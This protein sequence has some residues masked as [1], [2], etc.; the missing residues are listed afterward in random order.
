MIGSW[1]IDQKCKTYMHLLQQNTFFFQ[2]QLIP[3]GGRVAFGDTGTTYET[4]SCIAS[5]LPTEQA[6]FTAVNTAF[7][8]PS[9]SGFAHHR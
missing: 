1:I 4:G 2:L 8:P 6:T 3:A 5:N 9:S 7:S